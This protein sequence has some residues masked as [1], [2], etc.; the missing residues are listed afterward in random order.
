MFF[1]IFICGLLAALLFNSTIVFAEGTEDTQSV[2]AML[3]MKLEV[4]KKMKYI[5]LERK[6]LEP[7]EENHC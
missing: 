7:K 3:Q 1:K 4:V 6:W 5:F 2:K